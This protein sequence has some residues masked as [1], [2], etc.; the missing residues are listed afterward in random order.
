[1]NDSLNAVPAAEKIETEEKK[2]CPNCG[3]SLYPQAKF[4]SECG[5]AF[6]DAACKSKRAER[7]LYIAPSVM[8]VV[9]SLLLFAIFSA[10]VISLNG[11]FGVCSVYALCGMDGY[12]ALNVLSILL[13]LFAVATLL[14]A[15]ALCFSRIKQLL[16]GEVGHIK[17]NDNSDIM[18]IVFYL[19]Y[20]VIGVVAIV[21]IAVIDMVSLDACPV[22]LTV[23]SATFGAVNIAISVLKNKMKDGASVADT[24]V[25]E[26][27]EIKPSVK[28]SDEIIKVPLTKKNDKSAKKYLQSIIFMSVSIVIAIIAASLTAY[29]EYYSY[30]WNGILYSCL[31]V[32]GPPSLVFASECLY[33]CNWIFVAVSISSA[34]VAVVSFVQCAKNKDGAKTARRAILS[35]GIIDMLLMIVIFV[36]TLSDT[37]FDIGAGAVTIFVLAVLCVIYSIVAFASNKRRQ[38]GK[39]TPDR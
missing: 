33:V 4:C 9:F 18:H 24:K 22:L 5:H 2:S 27:N 23:F 1:M 26:E 17:S 15:A 37:R 12:T 31:L 34:V 19:L 29:S 35:F 7:I 10:P 32:F 14:T 36:I 28:S 20:A 30:D 13:V 38:R 25:V 39:A 16:I 8:F 6:A 3:Y 21:V 11:T